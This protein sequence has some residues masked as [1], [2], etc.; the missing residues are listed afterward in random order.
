MSLY[1][2]LMIGVAGLDANSKALARPMPLAAP[3]TRA[4]LP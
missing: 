4:V 1:D 2:A 3:V